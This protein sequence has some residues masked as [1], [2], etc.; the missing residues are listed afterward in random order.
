MSS[1][2]YWALVWVGVAAILVGGPQLVVFLAM[3]PLQAYFTAIAV[4]AVLVRVSIHVEES[5]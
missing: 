5:K 2:S 1:F 4:M 3:S